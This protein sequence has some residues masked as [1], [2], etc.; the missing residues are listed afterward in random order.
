MKISQRFAVATYS[1]RGNKSIPS[2]HCENFSRMINGK[3]IDFSRVRWANGD[4]TVRA[5]NGGTTVLLHK[6]ESW[7]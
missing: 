5:W 4:V 3:L 6:W 7:T 1:M 2:D